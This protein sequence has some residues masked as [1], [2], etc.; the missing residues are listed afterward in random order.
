EAAA[1]LRD[2][3]PQLRVL[4]VGVGE[5]EERTRAKAEELGIEDLVILTGRVPHAEI[6]A[7]YALMDVLVY[8]RLSKRITELV[9]ALKPLE[10]FA[11][12]KGVIGSDVGGMK[13]LLED[14]D[15]DRLFTAGS[16]DALAESLARW[17]E[18]PESERILERERSREAVARRR[19]WGGQVARIVPVY[20]ALV[21]E[22]FPK[23]FLGK[24]K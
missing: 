4:L 19:T 14:C 12:G 23:S 8:P 13:E 22:Q 21:G 18:T 20:Q 15:A 7:Y 3:H 16:A 24:E 5:D 10:A 17:I 11:M 1:K 9:T 2:S 6:C